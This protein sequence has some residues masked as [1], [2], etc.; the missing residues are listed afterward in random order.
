[1]VFREIG[2]LVTGENKRSSR[3]SNTPVFNDEKLVAHEKDKTGI[4][5]D[6]RKSSR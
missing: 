4:Y 2:V 5:W 6:Q 3:I 1:M